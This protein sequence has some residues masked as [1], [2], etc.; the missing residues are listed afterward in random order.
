MVIDG[1][2]YAN[3]LYHSLIPSGHDYSQNPL[4]LYQK[5]IKFIK[6]LKRLKLKV[7]RVYIDAIMNLDKA[8]TY[9]SRR[10]KS[11]KQ[12][13]KF[14]NTGLEKNGGSHSVFLM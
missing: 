8:D 11:Q 3:H 13:I 4:F 1:L 5:T 7:I 9:V 12:I 6:L 2:S 10:I 14:W